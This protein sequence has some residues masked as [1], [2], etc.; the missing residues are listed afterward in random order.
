MLVMLSIAA[1]TVGGTPTTAGTA[2]ATS[3]SSAAPTSTFPPIVQCPGVGDFEEGRGITAISGEGSDSRTL[4]RV[5][6]DT[7]DQCETFHFAF[8]T[9]E[10]APATMLPDIRVDHLDSF[11]VV[12]INMN[13]QDTVITDQLVET[14]LVDRLY[15][16]RS[17]SG[18]MFVDLHLASPAAVR[19]AAS[20]SPARLSLDLRPGFVEFSGQST[21][22]DRIVLTSPLTGAEVGSTVQFLGYSRSLEPELVAI[23]TQNGE[24]VARETTTAADYL[25]NWGE[26]R[27]QV[28]LPP[29]QVSVFL[30]E[31][32]PEDG[33]L[34][35]I[36]VD[37]T[38]N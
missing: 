3:T 21:V 8:E 1:C 16:V 32:S 5:S 11:Q 28:D 22:G 17:L 36:T 6:W 13:V 20:S 37:L 2:P 25:E 10:G 38:V 27:L 35:G 31:E 14:N 33:N 12:R 24:V 23:V 19:V 18:S 9:S 7:S 26:Y 29:G 15:V 4:G 30:G 34:E